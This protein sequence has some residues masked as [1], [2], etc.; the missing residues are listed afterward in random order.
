M[1]QM[2]NLVCHTHKKKKKK[3]GRKK[4]EWRY[5]KKKKKKST[6]FLSNLK[7]SLLFWQ[8]GNTQK[9]NWK[10]NEAKPLIS[11]VLLTVLLLIDKTYVE[12]WDMV[13]YTYLMLKYTEKNQ[14]LSE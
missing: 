13:D 8:L 11:L 10:T 3:R 4:K 9:N 12:P 2:K 7:V 5:A 6:V 1:S 14:M